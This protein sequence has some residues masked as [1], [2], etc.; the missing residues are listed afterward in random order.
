MFV[1]SYCTTFSVFP[2]ETCREVVAQSEGRRKQATAIILLGVIGAYHGQDSA[3]GF[4]LGNLAMQTSKIDSL[5][6]LDERIIFMKIFVLFC[7]HHL[8]N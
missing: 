5:F 2:G 3:E 4:G 1:N 7:I 8:V 6:W